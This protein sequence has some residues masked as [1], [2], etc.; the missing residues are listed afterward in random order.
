MHIKKPKEEML[1]YLDEMADNA[2]KSKGRGVVYP[3]E[4]TVQID[5]DSEEEL[6]EF[7]QRF[8]LFDRLF[9]VIGFKITK[10]TTPNHYHVRI[11]MDQA[12]L[13]EA[14]RILF[15]AL[16]GSDFRREMISYA[17]LLA[18][19]KHPSVLFEK[20]VLEDV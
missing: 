10:S 5:L 4:F 1:K 18:G 13:N 17:R 3:N 12:V 19:D 8:E 16:L 2:S 6:V 20:I 14:E 9:K 15:Q 11:E 7:K